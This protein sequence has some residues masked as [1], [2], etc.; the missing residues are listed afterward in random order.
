MQNIVASPECWEI[1]EMKKN[2]AHAVFHH[3][4]SRSKAATDAL[5][6]LFNC[7]PLHSANAA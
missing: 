2:G 6:P 1:V 7:K 5:M 4:A 3:V